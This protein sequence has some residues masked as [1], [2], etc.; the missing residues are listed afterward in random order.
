LACGPREGRVRSSDSAAA[1]LD[2]GSSL[3]GL[4]RGGGDDGW[5]QAVSDSGRGGEW[6]AAVGRLSWARWAAKRRWA[7]ARVEAA[8]W[9]GERGCWAGWLLLGARLGCVAW[10]AG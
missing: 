6:L 10:W 5:A 1:A 4:R 7:V 9:A 3:A 8:G 2:S